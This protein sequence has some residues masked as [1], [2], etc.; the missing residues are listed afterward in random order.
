MIHELLLCLLGFTGDILVEAE[1]HSTFLVK[2]G[3][4]LLTPSERDQLNRIAPLGWYFAVLGALPLLTESSRR[5]YKRL[6]EY[7]TK[8]DVTWGSLRDIQRY[9]AALCLG[10]NDLIEEYTLTVAALE[11][12]VISEGPVPLSF[13]LQHFQTFLICFPATWNI[14]RGIEDDGLQ[15]CQILD[16]LSFFKS[17]IP[18]VQAVVERYFQVFSAIYPVLFRLF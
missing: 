15:G 18:V 6:E 16:H 2:P 9:K 8:H 1:D 5:Y 7:V 11:D 14:C 13:I 3:F 12:R 4:D 17:G 10:L